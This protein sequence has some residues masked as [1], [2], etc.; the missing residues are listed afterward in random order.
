[1]HLSIYVGIVAGRM[2]LSHLPCKEW[3]AR[4]W[5]ERCDTK[6]SIFSLFRRGNLFLIMGRLLSRLAPFRIQYIGSRDPQDL[7][8]PS[9]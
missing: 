8:E 7:A 2:Q 5:N 4:V 9:D 3:Y 1:V 6:E